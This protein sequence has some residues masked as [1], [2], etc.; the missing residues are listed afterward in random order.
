MKKGFLVAIV[1]FTLFARMAFAEA[2][3]PAPVGLTWH[4]SAVDLVRKYSAEKL[5]VNKKD[6]TTLYFIKRAPKKLN[7]F[8]SIYGVVHNEHGLVKIILSK[9]FVRDA[10]GDEGRKS[11]LKYKAILSE[12]YGKAESYEYTGKMTYSGKDEFYQCLAYQGCGGYASF[13]HGVSLELVGYSRGYGT[14]KITYV[15]DNMDNIVSQQQ[16]ANDEQ[17]RHAL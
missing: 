13:Y 14:L 16:Q 17:A 6:S 11:Y 3:Q 9:D 5:R 1:L 12:K 15:A 2:V 8:D 10:Y 4:T 7:D